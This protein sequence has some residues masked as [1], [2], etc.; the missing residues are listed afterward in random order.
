[1]ALPKKTRK[2]GVHLLMKIF[3]GATSYVVPFHSTS[4]QCPR[5]KLMIIL[6][7]TEE[8]LTKRGNRQRRV[9]H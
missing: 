7:L 2:Q 9:E 3:S 8:N 1:M 4:R 5:Q 6:N